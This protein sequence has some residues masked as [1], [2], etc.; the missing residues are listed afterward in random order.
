MKAGNRFGGHREPHGDISP[1]RGPSAELTCGRR[2]FT[3][4]ATTESPSGPPPL[5]YLRQ[6]NGLGQFGD[7]GV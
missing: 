2:K 3:G 6:L 7:E 4:T 5:P 1:V